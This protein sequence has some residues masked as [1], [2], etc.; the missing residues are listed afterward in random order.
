MQR[1]IFSI[2]TRG[3]SRVENFSTRKFNHH[4]QFKNL[5]QNKYHTEY[6]SQISY[7]WPFFERFFKNF[8]QILL[9]FIAFSCWET[10]NQWET[11]AFIRKLLGNY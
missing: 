2:L 8:A 1:I 9:L 3:G 5:H 6:S 4:C 7:F 10:G 11:L